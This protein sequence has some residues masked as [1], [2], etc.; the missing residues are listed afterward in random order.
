[1]LDL[2]TTLEFTAAPDVWQAAATGLDLDA[3]GQARRHW[4]AA[5]R[6]HDPIA[7]LHAMATPNPS[8]PGWRYDPL[9]IA[10]EI[11]GLGQ[12]VEND[13]QRYYLIDRFWELQGAIA[14]PATGYVDTPTRLDLAHSRLPDAVRLAVGLRTATGDFRLTTEWLATRLPPLANSLHVIV[15]TSYD[16]NVWGAVATG[17]TGAYVGTSLAILNDMGI[18]LPMLGD[19]IANPPPGLLVA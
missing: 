1:M 10:C 2:D 8:G 4:V 16:A 15:P 11:S 6:A 17:V 5:L 9:G 12:W 19:V 14:G 3:V 13:G 7:A 18:P